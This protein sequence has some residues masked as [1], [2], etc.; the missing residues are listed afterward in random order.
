MTALWMS[1]MCSILVSIN[2]NSIPTFLIF[3]LVAI[4]IIIIMIIV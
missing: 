1:Y 4:V 2:W 3:P